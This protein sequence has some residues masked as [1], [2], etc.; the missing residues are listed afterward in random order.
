M[1]ANKVKQT[2]I[3]VSHC[4]QSKVVHGAKPFSSKIFPLTGAKP[5]GVK[6]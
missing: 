6:N 4:P 1:S 2:E 3:E 5:F